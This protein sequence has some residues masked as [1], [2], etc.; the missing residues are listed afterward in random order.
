MWFG[1]RCLRVFADQSVEDLSASDPHG[2]EVNDGR[3]AV[4]GFGRALIEA[5]VRPVLVVV[6]DELA[7]DG[8]QV[9]RVLDQ[10][11]I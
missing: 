7:Q 10:H 11:P 4:H 1:L 6:R 5:L 3:R 8:Q 9:P 2:G